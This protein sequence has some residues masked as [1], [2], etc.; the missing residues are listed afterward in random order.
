M[1]VIKF[2]LSDYERCRVITVIN[3][4]KVST[5]AHKA[6]L[7]KAYH[8]FGESAAYRRIY[9]QREYL[10][11]GDGIYPGWLYY[12][13]KGGRMHIPWGK[14][15]RPFGPYI[16]YESWG[17]PYP[18]NDFDNEPMSASILGCSCGLDVCTQYLVRITETENSVIWDDYFAIKH[19]EPN[20]F[21]FEFEKKQYFKEVEKLID[22]TLQIGEKEGLPVDVINSYENKRREIASSDSFEEQFYGQKKR[23]K[24]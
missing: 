11:Y 3:G 12:E 1:D 17:G 16:P 8:T 14:A 2:K 9:S 21:H 7:L 23:F 24:F 6:K 20:Y 13:L 15:Y 18:V 19:N 4:T 5:F 22:L 10:R